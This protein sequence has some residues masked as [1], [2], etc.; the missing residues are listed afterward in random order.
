MR[1]RET[2]I[3]VPS[4]ATADDDPTFNH[5]SYKKVSLKRSSQHD[6]VDTFSCE[7]LLSLN[8]VSGRE[9]KQHQHLGYASQNAS[10]NEQT[11]PHTDRDTSVEHVRV[12]PFED[13]S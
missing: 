7:D 3:L 10:V 8:H 5:L 13:D 6:V 12:T 11:T 1:L 4:E 9:K 2:N